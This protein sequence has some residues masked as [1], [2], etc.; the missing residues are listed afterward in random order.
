MARSPIL[1]S[2]ILAFYGGKGSPTTIRSLAHTSVEDPVSS[3]STSGYVSGLK[4]GRGNF[5][6]PHSGGGVEVELKFIVV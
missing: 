4:S 6:T 1:A 3:Q 2:A 5:A